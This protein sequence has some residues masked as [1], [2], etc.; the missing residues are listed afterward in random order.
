M[1]RF[2]PKKRRISKEV[3][4]GI[5]MRIQED[6]GFEDILPDKV[7]KE[8]NRYILY[9]MSDK[10]VMIED[11]KSGNSLEILDKKELKNLL[12]VFVTIKEEKIF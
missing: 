1:M 12:D 4:D 5:S 11:K 3:T 10:S 9:Q 2:Y 7:L 6:I 8:N